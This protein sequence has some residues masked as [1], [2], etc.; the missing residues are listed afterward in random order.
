MKKLLK[1]EICESIN[2][3]ICAKKWK[4]SNFAATVHEQCMNN[5][6][7]G[8][9]NVCKRKKK[10]KTQNMRLGNANALPKHTLK[11]MS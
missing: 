10:K 11:L 7:V 9:S 2:S 5:S 8:L 6:R 4:K 1:N 3:K